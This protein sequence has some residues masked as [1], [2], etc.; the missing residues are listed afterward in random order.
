MNSPSLGYIW[1]DVPMLLKLCT[2][3]V[4]LVGLYTLFSGCLILFRLRSLDG[5]TRDKSAP[6]S[7]GHSLAALK[8]R[9]GVYK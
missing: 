6:L 4:W 7:L 2:L 5:R 1:R 8:A 9:L 3:I